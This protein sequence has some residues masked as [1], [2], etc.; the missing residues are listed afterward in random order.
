MHYVIYTPVCWTEAQLF[1]GDEKN[2]IRVGSRRTVQN[3]VRFLEVLDAARK[4]KS[5]IVLFQGK[6]LAILSFFES[7]YM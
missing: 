5:Q 7:S 1:F 3:G 4:L 6:C 2:K